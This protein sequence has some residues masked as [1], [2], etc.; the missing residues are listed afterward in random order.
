M[1]EWGNG[2]AL[3]KIKK[4][5]IKKEE[6]K[7]WT[8]YSEV[9]DR[10]EYKAYDLKRKTRKVSHLEISKE[11]HLYKAE[12]DNLEDKGIIKGF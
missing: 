1:K 11:I 4:K 3:L 10:T 6:G 7:L 5:K 9:G 8:R 2:I 12:I